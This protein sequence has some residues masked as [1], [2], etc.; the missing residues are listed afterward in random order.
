MI[1]AT[2][3]GVMTVIVAVITTW[4]Q[5]VVLV[6]I[7]MRLCKATMRAIMLVQT[8]EV[9]DHHN[10]HHQHN[11]IAII[12]LV[13]MMGVRVG[14]YLVI[15]QVNMKVVMQLDKQLV[16]RTGLQ[17]QHHNQIL[18]NHSHLQVHLYQ[19]QVM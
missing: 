15:I 8:L 12:K 4:I 2:I 18:Y 9:M 10:H 14:L 19:T 11:K 17:H 13:I 7:Q 5:A 16:H 6:L 1:L 3:T